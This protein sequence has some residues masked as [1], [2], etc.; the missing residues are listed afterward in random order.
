MLFEHGIKSRGITGLL[1]YRQTTS[2][3]SAG[4]CCQGIF[5]N[6][7]PNILGVLL[8][9]QPLNR[10]ILKNSLNSIYT[11]LAHFAR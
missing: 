1:L 5:D 6:S 10:V 7:W 8:I 4:R 2:L 3:Q 11:F 9:A